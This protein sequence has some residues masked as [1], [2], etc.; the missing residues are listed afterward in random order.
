MP[1]TVF[2]KK[3]LENHNS[4]LIERLECLFQLFASFITDLLKQHS[5]NIRAFDKLSNKSLY[6]S[7]S[8]HWSSQFLLLL[9]LDDVQT[10]FPR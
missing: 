7:L 6:S 8:C 4:I 10:G 1:K 3:Y 5:Q 9:L 2:S